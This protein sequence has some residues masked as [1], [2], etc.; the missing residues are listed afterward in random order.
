MALVSIKYL[1][2]CKICGDKFFSTRNHAI[3]C[4]PRC[5]FILYKSKLDIEDFISQIDYKIIKISNEKLKLK[6]DYVESC[7]MKDTKGNIFELIDGFVDSSEII[8]I[9]IFRNKALRYLETWFDYEMED[10]SV[11]FYAF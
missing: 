1:K 9:F 3:T 7:K 10:L 6:A 11:K 2:N 4:S 8:K 5:R